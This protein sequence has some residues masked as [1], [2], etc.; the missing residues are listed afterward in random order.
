M[1]APCVGVPGQLDEFAINID[2]FSNSLHEVPSS[3]A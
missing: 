1:F 2:A 3:L